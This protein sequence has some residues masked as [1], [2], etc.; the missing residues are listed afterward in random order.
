MCVRILSFL[1]YNCFSVE[2]LNLEV[3]GHRHVFLRRAEGLG[4]LRLEELLFV[5]TVVCDFSALLAGDASYHRALS[6]VLLVLLHMDAF[7]QEV[8]LNSVD[9]L[10]MV[11]TD[12]DSSCSCAG[13]FH[14]VLIDRGFENMFR[15]SYTLEQCRVCVFRQM[16]NLKVNYTRVSIL[17][18]VVVLQRSLAGLKV[19]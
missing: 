17:G 1:Y 9:V 6:C 15:S 11:Q 8:E 4:L 13:V 18:G 5:Q 3:L 14:R 10:A 19:V 12:L 7:S 2:V 16:R